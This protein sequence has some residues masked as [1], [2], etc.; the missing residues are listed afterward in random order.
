M[1]VSRLL[2]PSTG[3]LT[4]RAVGMRRGGER[5]RVRIDRCVRATFWEPMMCIGVLQMRPISSWSLDW[6]YDSQPVPSVTRAM[7]RAFF[8]SMS[9]TAS[10]VVGSS[11]P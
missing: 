8:W 10:A 7:A 11:T 3:R 4:E 9:S 1:P 6:S 2:A 5:V